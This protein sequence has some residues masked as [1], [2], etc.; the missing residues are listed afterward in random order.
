MFSAN[1][2]LGLCSACLDLDS[3]AVQ[4]RTRRRHPRLVLKKH[5]PP[6]AAE[7][8]KP[9]FETAFERLEWRSIGPA[10][11]GGRTADVEGFRET[12]MSFT[13]RRLPGGLLENGE[14]GDDLEADFRAAGNHFHRGHRTRSQ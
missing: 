12:R 1:A 2:S 3:T 10:N 8:P 13:S 11:M 7:S 6:S 14:R 9:P 4:R 5:P